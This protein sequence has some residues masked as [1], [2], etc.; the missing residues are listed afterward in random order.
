MAIRY[1]SALVLGV[2]C[3]YLGKYMV[4]ILCSIFGSLLFVYNFGFMIGALDNYFEIIDK[5]K[6]GGEIVS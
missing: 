2:V 5:I 1:S 6:S 4:I 3:A